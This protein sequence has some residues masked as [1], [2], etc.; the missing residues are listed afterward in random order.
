ML[1]QEH[2]AHILV[3]GRELAQ[4]WSQGSFEHVR[5][6]VCW[7]HILG[8]TVRQHSRSLVSCVVFVIGHNHNEYGHPTTLG[9]WL[10]YN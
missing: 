3:Q 4:N 6:N 5:E 10:D 7:R 2:C 1:V 9:P 8:A